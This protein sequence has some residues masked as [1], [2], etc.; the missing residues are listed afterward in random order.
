MTYCLGLSLKDGLVLLADTRTNAG[1]DHVATFS[2]LHVVERPGE[3]LIAVMTAGNLAI[4]QSV[5][6]H[7]TEGLAAG[8]GEPPETLETVPSMFQAARLVGRAVREVHDNDAKALSAQGVKFDAGFL[9]AGQI[10]GRRQR[11]FQVYSAGNF[12][13][14]TE[15]TPYLQIGEHKYG[16][17]ILDR[18][19]HFDT[20]L[21]EAVKLALISMDSTLRSNLSV[22]PPID[23][24]VSRRDSAKLGFQRRIEEDDPYFKS[25]R[26]GWSAALRDAYRGMPTPDWLNGAVSDA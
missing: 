12:I 21:V 2:K 20:P 16:K 3:R 10:V 22:G 7:L 17:P 11:L 23:L 4:T 19:A 8:D 18:V 24:I 9:V 15:D 14:A 25:I 6:S 13:E 26:D 1:V 5:I